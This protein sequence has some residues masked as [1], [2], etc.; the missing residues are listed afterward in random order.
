MRYACREKDTRLA[1]ASSQNLRHFLLVPLNLR[2][3]ELPF[4]SDLIKGHIR[5]VV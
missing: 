5:T 2:N 1:L 3:V 4:S